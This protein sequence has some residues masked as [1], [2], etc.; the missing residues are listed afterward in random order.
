MKVEQNENSSEILG[1]ISD[2]DAKY[3][4]KMVLERHKELTDEICMIAKEL[5]SNV[6]PEDIAV[7]VV[8]SLNFIQVEELWDRSGK[9]RYGYVE[10]TEE[11]LVM[12]EET[13]IEKWKDGSPCQWIA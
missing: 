3:I 13:V 6:D 4:L 7:D 5:L 10:I 1:N 2:S 9:T 11:A 12:F 8:N